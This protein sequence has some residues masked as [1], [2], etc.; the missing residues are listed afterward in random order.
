MPFANQA[1]H[2]LYLDS[3][4]VFVRIR[5]S[6]QFGKSKLN[7]RNRLFFRMKTTVQRLYSSWAALVSVQTPK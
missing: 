2:Q 4:I 6:C 1:V 3:G 5:D 7:S